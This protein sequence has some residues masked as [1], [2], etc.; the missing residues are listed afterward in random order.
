MT[1]V[2]LTKPDPLRPIRDVPG[3]NSLF[4]GLLIWLTLLV[5]AGTCCA[6][7]TLNINSDHRPREREAEFRATSLTTKVVLSAPAVA[8]KPP[9]APCSWRGPDTPFLFT[10]LR[11]LLLNLGT[12][13]EASPS[14]SAR[15]VPLLRPTLVGVVELRI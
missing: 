13:P 14:A 11:V 2:R 12:T 9:A 6:A 3:R 4:Q 5:F 8:A 7:P 15:A 10:L 1:E